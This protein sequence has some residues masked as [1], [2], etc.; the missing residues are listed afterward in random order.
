MKKILISN[1]PQ[2][3]KYLSAFDKSTDRQES[4]TPER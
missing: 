1:P 2:A 4:E 3:D